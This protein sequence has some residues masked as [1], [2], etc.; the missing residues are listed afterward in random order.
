MCLAASPPFFPWKCVWHYRLITDRYLL[1]STDAFY[2]KNSTPFRSLILWTRVGSA[3]HETR[4]LARYFSRDVSCALAQGREKKKLLIPDTDTNRATS[5][6]T[7]HSFTWS[8]QK[9]S[10]HGHIATIGP[11]TSIQFN[12]FRQRK[13]IKCTEFYVTI[14]V[15]YFGATL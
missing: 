3:A 1:I 5:T 2:P 12:H 6:L 14:Q 7:K 10:R 8:T 15:C 9:S 4:S 11:I 13:C